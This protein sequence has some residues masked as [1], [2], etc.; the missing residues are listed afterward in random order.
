MY[1][2]SDAFAVS[3]WRI[4]SSL[5]AIGLSWQLALVAVA[6][7]NFMTAL[8]VTYNVSDLGLRAEYELIPPI[9]LDWS[10]APYSLHHSGQERLWF[11]LRI[12]YDHL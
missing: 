10:K 4:G 9:G 1:W 11:L 12:R 8:V 2:I 6:I 7:G 3:N 5:I